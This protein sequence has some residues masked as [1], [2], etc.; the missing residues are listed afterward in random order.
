[1]NVYTL[2]DKELE[3]MH[4][5]MKIYLSLPVNKHDFP[6]NTAQAPIPEIYKRILHLQDSLLAFAKNSDAAIQEKIAELALTD[7]K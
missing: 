1:M 7:S 6:H 4:D 2:L 5:L 3:R